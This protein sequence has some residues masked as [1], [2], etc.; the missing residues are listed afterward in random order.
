VC[1][2]VINPF[3]EG[4]KACSGFG[5]KILEFRKLV[6]VVGTFSYFPKVVVYKSSV[7]QYITYFLFV[8]N[9]CNTL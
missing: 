4:N 8:P 2:H 9:S 7:V 6:E 5:Q 1:Y 3:K